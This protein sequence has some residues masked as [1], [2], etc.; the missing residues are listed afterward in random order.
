MRDVEESGEPGFLFRLRPEAYGTDVRTVLTQL[1]VADVTRGHLADLQAMFGIGEKVLGINDQILGAMAA[2][3]RK[4]ATEV[5]TST[6]FGVNRLKTI[7]EYLSATCFSP[8][9][10]KL[11]QTSQQYYD[12]QLKLRIVGDAAMLAGPQF[13]DVKPQDILG[14]FDF[15]PVDGTLPIDR[16]AQAN[17]WKELILS[18]RQLPQLLQEYDLSKIFA[19]TAQI[20]GLKNINQFRLQVRPQGLLANEAAAGNIVPIRPGQAQIGGQSGMPNSATEAGMN[21]MMPPLGG[22]GGY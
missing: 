2:G 5:R 17:L 11:V 16:L 14:A 21:A 15:V 22:S 6:G 3:G 18:F 20:A 9:A 7:S 19:Y 12:A 8:H 10:Q 4:T 13:F 1:P